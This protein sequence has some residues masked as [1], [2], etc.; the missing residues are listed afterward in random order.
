MPYTFMN[1]EIFKTIRY[2]IDA[3]PPN[4]IKYEDLKHNPEEI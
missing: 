1:P 2:Q 3:P 4:Y